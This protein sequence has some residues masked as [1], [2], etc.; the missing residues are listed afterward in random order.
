MWVL[1]IEPRGPP[2]FSKAEPS[3]QSQEIVLLNLNFEQYFKIRGTSGEITEQTEHR[4]VAEHLQSKHKALVKK[5]VNETD[6]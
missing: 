6:I 3:F 2:V 1:R 5:A 4:L